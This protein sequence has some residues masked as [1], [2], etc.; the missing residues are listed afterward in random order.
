VTGEKRF[1]VARGAARDGAAAIEGFAQLLGSRRVG[2]RAVAR[3]LTEVRE[4]CATLG[5][6]LEDL[7]R[8]LGEILERDPEAARAAHVLLKDARTN[9]EVL[10]TAL[11]SHEKAAIDARVRLALEN[12]VVRIAS[13]I[14]GALWLAD[15]LAAAASPRPTPLGLAD[16][17]ADRFRAF[18]AMAPPSSKR[19]AS[20][21]SSASDPPK[22]VSPVPL[23]GARLIHVAVRLDGPSQLT[24][25]SRVV[26]GLL[27]FAVSTAARAGVDAPAL[28]TADRDGHL[29][30]RIG[31]APQPS[32]APPRIA[33]FSLRECGPHAADIARAAARLS[34]FELDIDQS[35]GG[36]TITL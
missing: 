31:P 33:L 35:L 10:F 15:L 16:M 6:A 8:S 24:G 22:P 34:G 3:A 20:A 9:A 29:I 19:S 23:K 7:E 27:E 17:L 25:D 30:L 28:T 2:P 13:E 12:R 18:D 32:Q 14:S 21:R 36:V 11:L 5:Q 26:S 4:G 1:A